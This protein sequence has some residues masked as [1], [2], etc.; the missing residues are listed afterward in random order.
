MFSESSPQTEAALTEA[1][2]I[3]EALSRVKFTS[4]DIRAEKDLAEQVLRNITD[5]LKPITGFT[6][7]QQKQSDNIINI[8]DKLKDI[9]N[10]SDYSVLTSE[11][12]NDISNKIK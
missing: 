11:K 9:R 4:D 6:N 2:T 1:K 5:Y 3:V 10:Q 12:A 7:E 8:R